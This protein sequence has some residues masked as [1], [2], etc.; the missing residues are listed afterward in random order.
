MRRILKSIG[1]DIPAPCRDQTVKHLDRKGCLGDQPVQRA[2]H[3]MRA[4]AR[5]GH[6]IAPPLQPHLGDHRL[7]GHP[8]RAGDLK[9]KGVK[10]KQP[11]PQRHR[12]RH[13]GSKAVRIATLD[14]TSTGGKA[15]SGWPTSR[16]SFQLIASSSASKLASTILAETPTVDQPRPELSSLSMITRVTA[17]VPP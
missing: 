10:H 12:S 1:V 11:P 8:R 9:V 16:I 15:H 3:L 7:F 17:S 2:R 6:H 14:Q 13:N 4:R 5:F